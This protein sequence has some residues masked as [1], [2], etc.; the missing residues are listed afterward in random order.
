MV[1]GFVILVVFAVVFGAVLNLVFWGAI[2]FFLVS[3]FRGIARNAE[4]FAQ[5]SPD[6]QLKTLIYLQQHGQ[7]GRAQ[8]Y[9]GSVEGPVQSEIG[10]LAA[11]QGWNPS[12]FIG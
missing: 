5:M 7:I 12:D 9:W 11:Q 3:V 4:Q 2:A 10:S 1:D 8:Q 6:E